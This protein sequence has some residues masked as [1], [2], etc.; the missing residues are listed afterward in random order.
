MLFGNP[1]QHLKAIPILTLG[2][3]FTF[4]TYFPSWLITGSYTSSVEDQFAT[5]GIDD[6]ESLEIYLINSNLRK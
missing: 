5:G 2:F 4:N 3:I 6:N 1:Y